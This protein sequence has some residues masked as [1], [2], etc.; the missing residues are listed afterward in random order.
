MDFKLCPL[1]LKRCWLTAT[2]SIKTISRAVYLNREA[3]SS[4]SGP[5]PSDIGT[6]QFEN[7]TTSPKSDET[8]QN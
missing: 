4:D 2:N 3:K 5:K 1:D 8:V 6:A 7:T